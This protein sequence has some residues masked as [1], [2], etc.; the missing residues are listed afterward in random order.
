MTEHITSE[1]VKSGHCGC[2]IDFS[3]IRTILHPVNLPSVLLT[4][5]IE[6][7]KKNLLCASIWQ[8][9]TS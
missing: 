1:I 7:M 6:V 9:N 8:T 3:E 4:S 5:T 2:N